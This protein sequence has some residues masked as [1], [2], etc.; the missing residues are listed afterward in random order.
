[1]I[2]VQ[3][4]I[5]YWINGAKDDMLTAEIFIEKNRLLQDRYPY[6]NHTIP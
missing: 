4:Q 1:M 5:E 2:D 6:Y 3:K